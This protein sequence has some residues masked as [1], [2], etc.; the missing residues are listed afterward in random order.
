MKHLRDDYL[1]LLKAFLAGSMTAKMFQRA[2]LDKF[3]I[4]NRPMEEGLFDV[5]DELFGDIDAFCLDP[6]LLAELTET[7][8]GWYLDEK[9]LRERVEEAV[10]RI[11]GI[12][13]NAD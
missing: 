1:E 7:K 3:K 6:A 12:A 8:P 9:A 13:S 5:L 11:V 2:Y 10:S 4:E